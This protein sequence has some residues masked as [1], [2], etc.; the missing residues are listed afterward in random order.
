[1]WLDGQCTG[2]DDD[3]DVEEGNRMIKKNIF[4]IT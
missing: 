2:T 1:M 4:F 3:D